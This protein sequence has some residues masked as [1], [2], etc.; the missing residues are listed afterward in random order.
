MCKVL[1]TGGAGFIGSNLVE[2]LLEDSRFSTVRVLDNFSNGYRENIKEFLGHPKFELIEGDI[3]D[4]KT[5]LKAVEDI[6]VVSH[7][8][9]LGSVPRSVKDPRTSTEVNI[10]GTVNIFQASVESKVSRVILAFSSST[11]GDHPGLPK[12]EDTIG[13]PLSPYAVTKASIEQFARVF[14]ETY[15]IEWI[16]L[17]YFNV[18]GPRQNPKNPYAAVIPI[19]ASAFLNNQQITVNGDGNTSRDFTHVKNVVEM[20]KLA[21]FTNNRDAL[22]QTYNV[23]CGENTSLNEMIGLLSNIT[24]NSVPVKYGPE[25]TG[26]VKHS[27]ASIDKAVRLLA[28]SPTIMFKEGLEKVIDWYRANL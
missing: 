8:A 11:Y 17:R 6:N 7:Q 24:G 20:N 16:G 3:R 14:G 22:N 10:L 28:Y 26:D 2:D 25:R 21:M 15:G 1:I 12:V 13:N 18:F 27:L 19:F 23:A 5:C 4:F 9:A